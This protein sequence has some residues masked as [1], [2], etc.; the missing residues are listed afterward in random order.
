MVRKD[1]IAEKAAL[2]ATCYEKGCILRLLALLRT[3]SKKVRM[4][5]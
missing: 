2:G 5:A 1:K 3:K 4:R